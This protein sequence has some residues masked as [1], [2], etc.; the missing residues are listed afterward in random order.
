MWVAQQ[1]A[2]KMLQLRFP[3]LWLSLGWVIV[4]LAIFVCLAPPSAPGLSG[5]FALNDKVEHGA[6]YALLT[7][8]FTGIYPRSRYFSIALALFAMGV[9]VEFLQGW[10]SLGR[11]RDMRDVV[12][13]TIGIGIGLCLAWTVLG[14]WVQRLEIFFASRER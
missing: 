10:M 2:I 13:N 3:R 12:A 1:M 7:V 8:W 9:A 6:G 4:M 14:G 11:D 5:L